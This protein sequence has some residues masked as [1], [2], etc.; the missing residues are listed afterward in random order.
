MNFLQ[1]NASFMQYEVERREKST[2]SQ[3]IDDAQQKSQSLREG[4]RVLPARGHETERV[5]IQY[6]V[7]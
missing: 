2:S 4:V 5:D 3:A 7:R 1:F 6:S